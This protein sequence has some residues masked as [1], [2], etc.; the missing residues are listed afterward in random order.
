MSRSPDDTLQPRVT[1]WLALSVG[2]LVLAGAFALF[3]VV[4]RVPPFSGL[5]TDPAFFKR[6]LV[7]HVDL[8]LVVWF[9][10]F[11]AGLIALL[12]TRGKRT[13]EPVGFGLAVLGVGLLFAGIFLPGAKPVLSNYIPALDSPV[14]VAGIAAFLFGVALSLLDDRLLPWREAA[15]GPV[16]VPEPARPLLRGAAVAYLLA[17]LTFA[18]AAVSTPE[19][20]P[21]EGRFELFFWGGGHVL[22][23]A[24][25]L[26]M[27]AVWVMLLTP[28]LGRA[29]V[30][31]PVASTLGALLV[32]PVLA[33]PVLALMGTQRGEVHGA[34]TQLMRWGIFPAVVVFLGLCL[35]A[36][37]VAVRER[38]AR[39]GDGRVLAF[40]ASAGLTVVGFVL[41]ALIT[42]SN[43]MVPAHYH[44]AIGAVTAAFMGVT[45]PLLD[46]LGRPAATPRLSRWRRLQPV[47]FGVGQFV[48]AV[49]FALAGAQGMARKAYGAEQHIRTSLEW[50]GLT[51]MGLGGLVAVASGVFFLTY[52]VRA[53]W[54]ASTF[55]PRRHAWPKHV[56]PTLSRP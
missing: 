49:G 55:S 36:V 46:A 33:A 35:R 25:E 20:L 21:P 12:P 37:Q 34:F 24:S 19:G 32:L 15:T 42:G 18:G 13:L 5:V 6:C 53:F 31:R 48:F 8:S 50:A 56:E 54:R 16:A 7:V 10:A 26:A 47:L 9:Y 3:L 23:V 45:Y 4:A 14:F 40:F 22:Q 28:A 11:L 51:V 38:R 43:T 41:G 1:R 44:A 29:P 52:V 30:T 17:L 27:L 39:L 2:S